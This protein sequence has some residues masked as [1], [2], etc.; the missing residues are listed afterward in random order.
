MKGLMKKFIPVLVIF[1]TLACGKKDEST[2]VPTQSSPDSSTPAT[3]S[4][5]VPTPTPDSRLP[6]LTGAVGVDLTQ[7]DDQNYAGLAEIAQRNV[8]SPVVGDPKFVMRLKNGSNFGLSGNALFAFEDKLGFEAVQI[9]SFG[10][11]GY[12]QNNVLDMI[13]ASTD[14][15]FRVTGSL[16]GNTL[17]GSI[18]YRLRTAGEATLTYTMVHPWDS[19]K[20][21]TTAPQAYCTDVTITCQNSNGVTVACPNKPSIDTASPC[22][23]FMSISDTNVKKLGNF[24]TQYSSWITLK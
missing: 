19:S 14:I 16:S 8:I 13:F 20:T 1:L 11:T 24:Q 9:S 3:T 21:Y 23:S 17:N 4:P 10:T 12:L 7:K 2:T 6:D 15:L 22:R 18:Y 5:V